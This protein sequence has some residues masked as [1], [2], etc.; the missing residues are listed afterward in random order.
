MTQVPRTRV[1]EEAASRTYSTRSPASA[2]SQ[3]AAPCQTRSVRTGSLRVISAG[4]SASVTGESEADLMLTSLVRVPG[5]TGMSTSQSSN[6]KEVA[7]AP[8]TA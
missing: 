3:V 5:V 4:A 1:I 7:M 6:S 2:P 8:V